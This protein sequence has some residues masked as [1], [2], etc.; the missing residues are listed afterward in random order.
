VNASTAQVVA[1]AK[2][3]ASIIEEKSK[4]FCKIKYFFSSLWIMFKLNVLAV[5]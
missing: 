1:T 5:L 3:C 4:T 2:N